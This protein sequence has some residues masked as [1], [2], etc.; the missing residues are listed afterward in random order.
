MS[1]AIDSEINVKSRSFWRSFCC[2]GKLLTETA[3]GMQLGH[4]VSGVLL[5][6][7]AISAALPLGVNGCCRLRKVLLENP[8]AVDDLLQALAVLDQRIS[9]MHDNTMQ[10]T[11]AT[12]HCSERFMP[13][14]IRGPASATSTAA[15]GVVW[16]DATTLASPL[17]GSEDLVHLVPSD[18]ESPTGTQHHSR[19]AFN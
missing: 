5:L 1:D 18:W 14:R 6:V 8:K 15:P 4:K 12:P 16:D 2:N 3:V 9:G 7:T 11:A 19:T 10:S 13:V 17:S